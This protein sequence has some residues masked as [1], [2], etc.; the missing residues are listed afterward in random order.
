MPM[1][2]SM[3]AFRTFVADVLPVLDLFCADESIHRVAQHALLIS[4]RRA[5]SLVDCVSF[6]S[7]RRLGLSS[8]FC[9]DPHFKELGFQPVG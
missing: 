5:L 4:N 3:A 7:M 2:G 8:V 6:E 1:T 9:F